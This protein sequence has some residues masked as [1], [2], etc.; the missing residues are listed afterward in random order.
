METTP[1]SGLA[2]A[3]NS[4]QPALG[5]KHPDIRLKAALSSSGQWT[6]SHGSGL[7]DQRG[8]VLED[9]KE[10]LARQ[11]A[12]LTPPPNLQPWAGGLD[13]LTSRAHRSA[14][15]S[16]LIVVSHQNVDE[17]HFM[18]GETASVSTAFLLLAGDLGF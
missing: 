13:R 9:H 18:R 8:A 7:R 10:L 14:C 3:L 1:G 16:P 11:E 15:C 2:H 5:P 17:L 6:C 12:L 4:A